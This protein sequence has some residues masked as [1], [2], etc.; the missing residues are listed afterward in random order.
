MYILE[1]TFKIEYAHQL[2]LP[3]ISQCTNIHGH[4][5]KI[6]IIL[7]SETLNNE[8]MVIDFSYLKKIV[9]PII[10][11][12]DHSF[13]KSKNNNVKINTKITEINETNS[14]AECIAKHIYEYIKPKLPSHI[15]NL[16]V[17]FYETENNCV[18]YTK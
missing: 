3:Y 6:K 10:N 14:T 18:T 4:S 2:S 1:K 11:K 15:S 9:Q 12:L 13:I 7:E 5:A 16:K 17:T 8:G